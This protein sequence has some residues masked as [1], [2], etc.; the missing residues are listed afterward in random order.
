MKKQSDWCTNRPALYP[1]G[2][3][4]R[5]KVDVTE[6]V[7]QTTQI[8][9]NKLSLPAQLVYKELLICIQKEGPPAVHRW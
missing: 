9:T 6:V 1:L 3:I 8:L 4:S 2:E 5:N 7:S